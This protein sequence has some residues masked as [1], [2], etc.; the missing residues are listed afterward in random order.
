MADDKKK[1]DGIKW[2]AG[3]AALVVGIFVLALVFQGGATKPAPHSATPTPSADA[4]PGPNGIQMGGISQGSFGPLYQRRVANE[5]GKN[6]K[7][8]EAKQQAKMVALQKQ[9]NDQAQKTAAILNSIQQQQL[10]LQQEITAANRRRNE[11]SQGI[12]YNQMGQSGV[13]L[14]HSRFSETPQQAM[15]ASQPLNVTAKKPNKLSPV[16]ASDGFVKGTL[17]NGVEASGGA[18]ASGLSGAG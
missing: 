18:G 4:Q 13:G 14:H 6:F 5:I 7:K 12:Q 16:I 15:G 3:S 11:E 17:L 10:Q 1:N 2:I 8:L 9:Q